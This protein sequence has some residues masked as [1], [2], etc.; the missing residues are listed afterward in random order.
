MASATGLAVGPVPWE[1]SYGGLSAVKAPVVVFM[2]YPYTVL[3]PKH[4]I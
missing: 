1:G 2:R 3:E 4:A